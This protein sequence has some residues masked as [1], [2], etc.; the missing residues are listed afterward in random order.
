MNDDV[1]VMFDARRGV[2][3]ADGVRRPGRASFS[4]LAGWR[5]CPGRWLGDRLF[6]KDHEWGDARNVGSICHGAIE[7]AVR[8]DTAAPDWNRLCGSAI[9]MIRERNRERGWGDDPAPAVIMPDGR[10][11]ADDDWARSAA[12]RLQDFDPRMAVDGGVLSP[13]GTE[14]G[15]DAELWGIRFTGSIDYMDRSNVIVDWKTG[16]VPTYPD[17]RERHADQLRL[18]ALLYG[19]DGSET[20]RDVYVEHGVRVDTRLDKPG[21]ERL[22]GWVSAAWEGV[23]DATGVD[24][25]GVFPLN[26]SLLCGW[27]PLARACPRAIVRSPKARKAAEGSI[28]ADDPRVG[29]VRPTG[30]HDAGGITPSGG[31]SSAGGVM[32]LLDMLDDTPEKEPVEPKRVLPL[33]VN[34]GPGPDPWASDEGLE[35]LARWGLGGDTPTA[36]KPEPETMGTTGPD[37]VKASEPEPKKT[38]TPEPEPEPKRAEAKTTPR[39]TADRKPETTGKDALTPVVG[40]PYEPTMTG[41]MV[42][43]AG[44]GFGLLDSTATLALR[45]TGPAHADDVPEVV[46]ALLRA[47]WCV[48]RSTWGE[49][50]VPDVDGLRDGDPNKRRLFT[51]LDSPLCRDADRAIRAALDATGAYDDKTTDAVARVGVAARLATTALRAATRYHGVE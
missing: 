37:T 26:P 13:V 12:A 18:Y 16:R 15:L 43:V 1:L 7:L 42:N 24:G 41:S 45:L 3:H 46:D 36:E 25:S 5:E 30:T 11:A 31:G 10:M 6:P 39:A 21:V 22:H 17:G 49:R 47:Q 48:A 9:R 32:S 2:A 33:P 34:T 35:A 4:M 40:K 29:F 20:L 19:V 38:N 28:S 8:N 27:C 44:Y 50:L 23:S 51:W 14:I